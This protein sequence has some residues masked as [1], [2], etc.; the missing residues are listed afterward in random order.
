MIF[1]AGL[2]TRLKH[3][4]QNRPKAMVEVNG[5]PM[6]ASLLHQLASFGITDFVVNVHHFA[7]VLC[8]YL[9]SDEFLPYN[10]QISD[11]RDC[12]LDTGGGLLKA[13]DFFHSD[14]DI[15]V[16]N[17]D[18]FSD[19]NFN[20]FYTYHKSMGG[21]ATL[22]VRNRET[23]R[24]L[25]FNAKNDLIG[26]K[27]I[28][29]D[30]VRLSRNESLESMLAFSGIQ[31]LSADFL[32]KMQGSGKFSI[33]DT[34]LELAKT[35]TIKAYNHTETYWIDLGKPEAIVKHENR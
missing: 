24:Y 20:E 4:T 21:I 16:H 11:E 28:K 7:D 10:I 1:A 30:E 32:R 14:E 8:N 27:N 2:G 22:A 19:I 17:V 6:I 5:K 31:F 18:I 34:Y 25:L 35:E 33:I 29:T 12:L 23:S 3:L 13:R 15:L 9:K 26:W